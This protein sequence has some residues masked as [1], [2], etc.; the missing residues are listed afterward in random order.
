MGTYQ[1]LI[2]I[3]IAI[4]SVI[5]LIGFEILSCFTSNPHRTVRVSHPYFAFF[6]STA[7]QDDVL[8]PSLS[9]LLLEAGEHVSPQPTAR[10]VVAGI[11]PAWLVVSLNGHLCLMQLIYP[12]VPVVS[13]QSAPPIA[14]KSC[15]SENEAVEG[16]LVTTDSLVAEAG[17]RERNIV[18]GIVPDGVATVKIRETDGRAFIIRVARN[19]YEA[20]ISH[21]QS[22][23]FLYAGAWHVVPVKSFSSKSHYQAPGR[24][25]F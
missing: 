5:A 24:E 19:A 3:R 6:D 9:P 25:S 13:G 1:S 22:V 23:E 4:G 11:N 12:I 20:L 2:C 7:T 17:A 15:A 21:P 18:V 8:P 10:R 14:S 16:N